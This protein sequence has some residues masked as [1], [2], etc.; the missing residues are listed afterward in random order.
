MPFVA[1]VA[2]LMYQKV[3]LLLDD[4]AVVAAEGDERYLEGPWMYRTSF[5]FSELHNSHFL[6]RS[7]C[8]VVINWI[9]KKQTRAEDQKLKINLEWP[10]PVV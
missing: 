9:M 7:N 8:V 2:F 1:A 4:I 6:H 3:C 10:F 5:H